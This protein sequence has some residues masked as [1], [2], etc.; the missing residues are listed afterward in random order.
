MEQISHFLTTT[1]GIVLVGAIA[2]EIKRRRRKLREV[3]DV[4][5]VDDKQVVAELDLMVESGV[6]QPFRG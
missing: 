4:L 5:D 2:Y 6:L 3:Y 1:F